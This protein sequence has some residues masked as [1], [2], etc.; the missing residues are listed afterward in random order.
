MLLNGRFIFIH[1]N[2]FTE[3]WLVGTHGDCWVNNILFRHND[4]QKPEEVILVDFQVFRE[5]CPTFDLA[6]FLFTSVR[7]SIRNPRE[8]ELFKIYYNQVIECCEALH[9]TPPKGFTFENLMRRWRRAKI[10]GLLIAMPLLSIVLKPQEEAKDLDKAGG[11][12]NMAE[13]FSSVMEGSD[14]NTLFRE[15]LIATVLNMYDDGI[16]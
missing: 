14:K 7:S 2:I 4:N 3:P 9:V 10:F 16:L 8:K 12:D 5:A 6:Y 13:M 15:E 11:D 1:K